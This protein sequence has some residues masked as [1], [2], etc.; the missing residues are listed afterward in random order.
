M[1]PEQRTWVQKGVK[2]G[3]IN[4]ICNISQFQLKI[5]R[6]DLRG[7]IDGYISDENEFIDFSSPPICSLHSR[8][9]NR[10]TTLTGG[11]SKLPTYWQALVIR[12]NRNDVAGSVLI[13]KGHLKCRLTFN[14]PQLK[15]NTF[16]HGT[17]VSI[18]N[19]LY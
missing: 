2:N 5:L 16:S 11:K 18:S 19:C 6:D 7:S 13:R 15:G 9:A 10:K 17:K 14:H 12:A 3:A 8:H 4:V 1:V